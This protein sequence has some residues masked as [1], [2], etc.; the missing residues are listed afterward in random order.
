MTIHVRLHTMQ[1]DLLL[2]GKQRC[3]T[4]RRGKAVRL[5]EMTDVRWT[6]V[7]LAFKHESPDLKR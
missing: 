3:I 4:N 6:V 1:E 5:T 7:I 2:K